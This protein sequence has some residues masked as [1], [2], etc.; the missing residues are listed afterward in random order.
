[1]IITMNYRD[2][3]NYIDPSVH[4]H[5]VFD[6]FFLHLLRKSR[7]AIGERIQETNWSKNKIYKSEGAKLSA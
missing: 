4:A 2:D 3:N 7:A 5:V 1:M 6:L